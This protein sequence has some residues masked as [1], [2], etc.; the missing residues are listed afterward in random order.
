MGAKRNLHQHRQERGTTLIEVL[1]A[2]LIMLLLMLGVL[3][4]FT[5]AYLQNL[6]SAARTDLTFRAQQFVENLRF[7]NALSNRTPVVN[8]ANTGITFPLADTGGTPHTVNPATDTYW[9]STG[10]NIV[11]TKSPFT[12][13][14]QIVD[15]SP[16]QPTGIVAVTVTI[17]P[18]TTGAYQYKGLGI[19]NKV[20]QYTAEVP[21]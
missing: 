16:G 1:I 4:M 12:L 18:L 13:A 14:Y 6:G 3:Q 19:R 21:K 7:L 10:A 11:T 15:P 9:G 5:M 17:T 2:L 8:V 20:I